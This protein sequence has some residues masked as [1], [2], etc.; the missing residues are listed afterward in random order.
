MFHFACAVSNHR[1]FAPGLNFAMPV[2][3]AVKHPSPVDDPKDLVVQLLT[4]ADED[5]QGQVAAAD[6]LEMLLR[7][8]SLLYDLTIAPRSVGFDPCNRD[9]EGG[10][11]LNVIALASEIAACGWSQAEVS[12]AICAEVVPHDDSVETFNR[13]L[14]GDSGMAPV[15]VNSI[16]YGSLA[17]GHTNYVLRCISAGVPST[18]EYL[19]E[20]GRMSETK[21]A[22]RDHLMAEVVASGLRWKVIRWEV[23][24]LY[25]TALPFIQRARNIASTMYRKESEIQG[26]LRLHTL[27]SAAQKANR[28]IPWSSI[29][30]SVLRSRPPF[31]DS[32]DEMIAFIMTR[33]GGVEGRFLQYLSAFYRN[34]VDSKRNSIPASLYTALADFPM[35]YVA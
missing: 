17:C 4:K 27:S 7:E 18:C 11:P 2:A 5:K 33:S 16:F 8:R 22:Q 35:H 26:L 21:L 34:H 1:G 31:A 25:P 9:G 6:Q 14:S 15:D 23:R 28:D 10:N 3:L 32:L 19:S 24:F 30:R 29:K 13:K 20:N 12:K